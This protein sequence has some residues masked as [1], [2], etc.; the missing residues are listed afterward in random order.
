MTSEWLGGIAQF[1]RL[2][3]KGKHLLISRRD[4][5]LPQMDLLA[6]LEQVVRQKNLFT[7]RQRILVAVSGGVDS[8]VLLEGLTRLAGRFSWKIAVGHFNHRLRG[9]ESGGDERFVRALAD[10]L[11]LPFIGERGDVRQVARSKGISV[12]MAAREL[13][14]DFL[15][16]AT[17]AWRAKSVALAHHADD[18]MELFFLRLFR[19][20][21]SEGLAGMKFRQ[22][23]AFGK[24]V[25]LVRPLLE[26]NREEIE[27][28]AWNHQLRYR[29]DSTNRTTEISRNK[30]R[31][32][33]LPQLLRDY[34]PSL[35]T[36]L[37][38]TMAILRAESEFVIG[39]AMDWM[40]SKQRPEF[41]QL[42]LAVKRAIV[43]IQLLQGKFDPGFDVV[44]RLLANPDEPITVEEGKRLLLTS[45]GLMAV[46]PELDDGFDG[47]E[48]D[49]NVSGRWQ[50]V[51]FGRRLIRYRR[52][53]RARAT[54]GKSRKIGFESFDADRLG[55]KL[56]LRHWQPGDRYCPIGM[57][58]SV[59]LQ[60]CFVNAKVPRNERRARIVAETEGGDI[61]WVEGLRIA[62]AYKIR[63]STKT[64]LEWN[65]SKLD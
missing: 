39:V 4:L 55:S 51:E 17:R 29:E 30:V 65:W 11:K 41:N 45:E 57:Q 13:R 14:H 23:S 18:Q 9:R 50:R 25:F 10:R 38:R 16:R 33:L 37:R 47:K 5:A 32:E 49:I 42:A 21:G 24:G 1:S 64:I 59:K 26:V 61:F 53:A 27:Q 63:P 58:H 22:Q 3:V 6:R 60:D 56:I 7:S 35:R 28:Y 20:A 34:Q 62:D 40:S 52:I 31:H 15:A 12:E 8:I 43:R 48:S 2:F 44:D 46:A 54:G 36:N 19:G